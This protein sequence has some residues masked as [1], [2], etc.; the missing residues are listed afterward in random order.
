MPKADNLL[1]VHVLSAIKVLPQALI[2]RRITRGGKTTK[3]FSH[4]FNLKGQPNLWYQLGL[5][6]QWYSMVVSTDTFLGTH[7]TPNGGIG[8]HQY[9]YTY[10]YWHFWKTK[11]ELV[12]PLWR[13][14]AHSTVPKDISCG[15]GGEVIVL[16]IDANSLPPIE[17]LPLLSGDMLLTPSF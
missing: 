8:G 14:P 12:S 5:F 10:Q 3:K 2:S 17:L 9:N 7:P 6:L 16:Q 11:K 1:N 13:W 4:P 15:G